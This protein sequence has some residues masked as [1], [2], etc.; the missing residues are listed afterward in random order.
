MRITR[1]NSHKNR[2]TVYF[3]SRD[4]IRSMSVAEGFEDGVCLT[5]KTTGQEVT[6]NIDLLPNEVAQVIEC[7]EQGNRERLEARTR[8]KEPHLKLVKCDT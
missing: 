4:K 8:K 1:Y 7:W 6:Y 5:F 3:D 2:G